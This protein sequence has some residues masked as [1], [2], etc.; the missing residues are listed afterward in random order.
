ME[1]PLPR[2]PRVV[3]PK[4]WG[5]ISRRA[6]SA[7]VS[8]QAEGAIGFAIRPDDDRPRARALFEAQ[9]V[10]EQR[11]RERLQTVV[12][13]AVSSILPWVSMIWPALVPPPVRAPAFAAWAGL[14]LLTAAAAVSEARWYRQMIHR[15]HELGAGAPGP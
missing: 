6:P 7:R 4:T 12:A 10:Y 14:L 13:L 11:R 2:K 1:Y 3:A 9:L 15:A 5:E 8:V